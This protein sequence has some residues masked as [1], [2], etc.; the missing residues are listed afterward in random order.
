MDLSP[1]KPGKELAGGQLT[2]SVGTRKV[3]GLHA[4]KQEDSRVPSQ[5]GLL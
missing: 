3:S 4:S 5:K 2:P 1:E